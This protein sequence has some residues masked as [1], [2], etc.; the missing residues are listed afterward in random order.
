MGVDK[1]SR[2]RLIIYGQL[3]IH[4]QV[5]IRVLNKIHIYQEER[6]SPH[7]VIVGKKVDEASVFFFL[8]VLKRHINYYM[9][10]YVNEHK[11]SYIEKC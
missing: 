3:I 11:K 4:R 7:I 5:S 9:D 2:N 8:I 6:Y 1:G 10:M